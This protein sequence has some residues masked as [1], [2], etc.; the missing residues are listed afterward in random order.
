M[1]PIDIQ[2]DAAAH[3][4][5][6]RRRR[7]RGGMRLPP[8][9]Q[10]DEHR[11]HRGA[12]AEPKA[13]ASPPRWCALRWTMRARWAGACGRRAATCAATCA[14]TPTRRT[15]WNEPPADR[16]ARHR[17]A[18]LLVRHAR[19]AAPPADA[20]RVVPQGRC[21]RCA[22]RAA[23]RRADRR[24]PARRAGRLGRAAAVGAGVDHRAGPVHT[25]HAARHGRHV[26][27]RCAGAGDGARAGGQ[28]RRPAPGGRAAAVRLPALRT[29]G[30]AGR[31][32]RMP[33][34][35]CAAGAAT[36]RRWPACWNGRR[37]TTTSWRASAAFRTAM[38]RS[39]ASRRPRRSIS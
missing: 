2:H 8:G 18:G 35:V 19:R 21:L 1:K 30:S 32:A 15:C 6:C 16:P 12:A 3:A 24:R 10:P 5:P 38:P 7:R 13:R 34:P 33:A 20:A 9:R 26:R 11:A 36:S 28:R 4:L 23:L 31:P 14:A 29:F 37:S 25:Q 39:A 22:D 17:G 27:R